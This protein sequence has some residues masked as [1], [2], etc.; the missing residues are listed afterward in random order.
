MTTAPS[1]PAPTLPARMDLTGAWRLSLITPAS[2]APAEVTSWG[3]IAATVPGTVHTDLMAAGL[4]EDPEIGTRE[5]DQHWIGRSE[6]SY[7]RTFTV[8]P[9][10]HEHTELVMAGLDTL[11]VVRVNGEVVAETKNQHRTYRVDVT[12]LLHE[13]ENTLEVRFRPIFEEIDRVEGEVGLL[14]ATEAI[15][16]PY[17]RKMACNF[18]WDWGPRFITAGIWREIHLESWSSARL[19]TVIPLATWDQDSGDGVLDVA[20]TVIGSPATARLRVTASRDGSSATTEES[21]GTD[22]AS[23][24]LRVP[25]A[26]PWWPSGYGDQPLYDV[27]IELLDADGAVLD[28]VTRRTGFRT[29]TTVEQPDGRGSTWETS[30][31]GQRVPVRGYDWIPDTCFPATITEERYQRRIDQAV[32]GGANMLRVWG[33]GIYESAAFYEYCDAR[34]VLVWQDFLFACAAYPETEDYAAEVEGEARDAIQERAHHPS[35]V[36]WNG[37]NECTWG[38]HDWTWWHDIL[39]GKAWGARYY[40]ELLPALIAE[41]DPSRPYI[42]GSPSSGDLEQAPNDDALGIQHLWEVWNQL[43]YVHYRDHDSSFVAEFGFCGPP[44]WAT[45][46]QAVPE[47]ELTLQNEEVTHHLRA[48]DG[49][50]KLDRGLAQHFPAPVPD[51]VGLGWS[52][53]DWHYLAQVNQARALTLGVDHLRAL[54]RNSGVV[55]W[56]LN[57]CW[58]VI[59]WA[60]VDSEERLKPLWYALRSAFATRR[61]T[62]QPT[63]LGADAA[64]RGEGALQLVAV[65]D[66]PGEWEATARV[67]RVSFTGEV[68]ASAELTLTAPAAGVASVEVPADVATPADPRSELIVVDTDGAGGSPGFPGGGVQRTTW[69]FER[70]KDLDYP[71]AQ[72]EASVTEVPGGLELTV[73][74]TTLLRDLAVFPDRL[75]GPDGT[76][77]GP[78]AAASD[79]LLTVLPGESVTI[80]LP[81]TL[82][83]HAELLT[84]RPVLRAVNDIV[85]R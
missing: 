78:E 74:A 84:S 71:Q 27:V 62:V 52:D 55:V 32:A 80:T 75:T 2:D 69:F 13:G 45:L 26:A 24:Q 57:D 19:G 36:L 23:V 28:R 31:N 18:G 50:I 20:A 4:L 33:G 73:Q 68:L 49:V 21:V 14:P 10:E 3:D 38:Y 70:D 35:L 15:H 82:P 83:E 16:Y 8:V 51:A 30:I 5:N 39:Q 54:Q 1:A 7:H 65:N 53:E 37:N 42:P 25:Q 85:H 34:G 11:A 66:E 77:L 76:A 17:V 48:A 47:G 12:E 22:G 46:R 6:W 81:G 60:A 72:W 63:S 79:L 29:V 9:G 41:L 64:T 43:D 58:P 59:S 44:T 56:Q 67:R 61:V 40:G